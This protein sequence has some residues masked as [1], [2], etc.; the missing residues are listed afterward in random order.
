MTSTGAASG[1]STSLATALRAAAPDVALVIGDDQREL[2][3][4]DGIPTFA[5]FTGRSLID[6]PPDAETRARIPRGV[7]AAHW[8]V[9]S[10]RPVIHPVDARAERAHR[11]AARLG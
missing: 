3:I 11:R 1:P 2:F 5:C 9:H 7:R 6:A 10:D 8:A 4:D